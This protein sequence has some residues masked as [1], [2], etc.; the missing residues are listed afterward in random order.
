MLRMNG[1]NDVPP[2]NICNLAEDLTQLRVPLPSGNLLASTEKHIVTS[3]RREASIKVDRIIPRWTWTLS[4]PR[5]PTM[6]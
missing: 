4:N 1:D 6:I 5:R 3:K 2:H